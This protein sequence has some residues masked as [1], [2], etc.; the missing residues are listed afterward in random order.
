MIKI[1]KENGEVFYSVKEVLKAVGKDKT[2]PVFNYAFLAD[3]KNSPENGKLLICSDSKIMNIFNDSDGFF[4]EYENGLYEIVK[5]DKKVVILNYLEEQNYVF[6]DAFPV[7][8]RMKECVVDKVVLVGR[9]ELKTAKFYNIFYKNF[10]GCNIA[11][12][13]K[14]LDVVFNDDDI[15]VS[16]NKFEIEKNSYCVPIY[17]YQGDVI[18]IVM[19]AQIF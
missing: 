3:D 8:D 5:N 13:Q 1:I 18:K 17:F 15:S 2:K 19:P 12:D 4:Q 11:V 14:F 16:F 9:K 7:I 6:P 10:P